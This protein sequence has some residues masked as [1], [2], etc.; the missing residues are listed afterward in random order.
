MLRSQY[1]TPRLSEHVV[2]MV[3]AEMAGQVRELVQEQLDGPEVR[4]LIAQK[5][6]APISELIVVHNGAASDCD[7]LQGINI[8]MGAAGPTVKD[9]Q[10]RLGSSQVS[11]DP[12][13]G[14]VATKW[15]PA[16]HHIW[17]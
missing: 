13:P 9:D 8:V 10:R 4:A 16:F 5:R 14:G 1:A 6:G 12:V 7:T 3:D 11:G 2:A 15:G 17:R